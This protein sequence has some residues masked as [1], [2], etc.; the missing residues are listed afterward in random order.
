MEIPA[1]LLMPD[2]S[3][4]STN[5]YF[6]NIGLTQ[7]AEDIAKFRNLLREIQNKT[8]HYFQSISGLADAYKIDTNAFSRG[9]TE[10]GEDKVITIETLESIDFRMTYLADLY[11]KTVFDAQAMQWKCVDN[12]REFDMN[13]YVTEIRSFHTV[14]AEFNKNTAETSRK[15][16]QIADYSP[17]AKKFQDTKGD[18]NEAVSNLKKE[19]DGPKSYTVL[20]SWNNNISVL[21]FK[22]KGCEFDFFGEFSLPYL[23]TISNADM[24]EQATM[25]IPITYKTV[26]EVSKYNIFKHLLRDK[27]SNVTSDGEFM[28]AYTHQ[29]VDRDS[30]ET[31]RTN[32]L[33]KIRSQNF[34]N[35]SPL[36]KALLEK[37]YNPDGLIGQGANKAKSEVLSRTKNLENQ[38]L[39]GNA[40]GFQ[41]DAQQ[42]LAQA[43]KFLRNQVSPLDRDGIGQDLGNVGLTGLGVNKRKHVNI[44]AEGSEGTTTDPKQPLGNAF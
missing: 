17:I 9:M 39:L 19:K 21:A 10:S 20:D 29:D 32:D 35:L 8:P 28:T 33:N 34:D 2:T 43:G 40:Y 13:I 1:G 15:K 14:T 44:D 42:L 4:H 27:K 37:G 38:A 5:K 24:G 11:R 22:F 30:Y 16:T 36:D 26:E 12:M 7:E 23:E 25:Q 41:A 18:F 3:I 6:K 31:S